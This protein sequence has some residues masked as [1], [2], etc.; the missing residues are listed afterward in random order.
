MREKL[1]NRF[2][3]NNIIIIMIILTVAFI[4]TL[5][6]SSNPYSN[7]MAGHDS[8]M[9]QYFGYAMSK[10]KI[11]YT[12]IFD[13]KGPMIFILN[14][15]GVIMN[16]PWTKGIYIIELAS[17]F[18]YYLFSYKTTRLWISKTL[19]LLLLLP[20]GIMLMDFLESG[21]L[22][23]EFA[24]PFIGLSLYIFARYFTGKN[25]VSFEI[26]LLGISCAIVFSLRANMVIAWLVF[27]LTIFIEKI[28]SKKYKEL[29]MYVLQFSIGLIIVF[30]PISV[31]LIM[32]GA[33]EAAFFQS[34]LF[35]MT[36]LDQS[37]NGF[38][39]F[40]TMY[41]L[42]NNHFVILTNTFFAASTLLKWKSF[43]HKEKLFSIAIIVFFGG[44]FA[45]SLLSGR[46]Y[47]HYL[48]TMIPTVIIPAGILLQQFSQK[49]NLKN[50]FIGLVSITV[51]FLPHVFNVY[52]LIYI[53]NISPV[54]TEETVTDLEKKAI[55][56]KNRTNRYMA[57]A[58]VIK[59]NSEESD[60][61]YVHRN[62]GN[63]Y[64][65]SERLSSIKYFNLPAVNIN[66]N[67]DIGEDFLNDII[68]SET[69]LIVLDSAYNNHEK[70]GVNKQ[71]FE[72]ISE[73]YELLSVDKGFYI[74]QVIN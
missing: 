52:D 1:T 11:M 70:A 26:I 18:I 36:Y 60:R 16:N 54:A 59:N 24:L 12:D 8:S 65:Y 63:L 9:F 43:S 47:K 23:E 72:Y 4:T 13:H 34:I 45:S 5:S 46:A 67:P 62:A 14:W 74:Y 30:L 68:N 2:F 55:E 49:N 38:D 48:M 61:I 33:F 3:L 35:N 44:S 53:K 6:V 64:L 50:I 58:N 42:L 51:L 28:W 57:V 29:M 31:Y 20:Q 32:N 66:N 21:N 27:C 25:V 39:V 7:T 73:N 71:F 19:S 37:S 10:G 69:K 15:L 40:R 41:D 56:N 17:I 22:T